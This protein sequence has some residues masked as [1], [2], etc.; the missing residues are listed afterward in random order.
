[1]AGKGFPVHLRDKSLYLVGIKGTGMSA[2][3]EILQAR[4]ARVCGS[5]TEETFYTDRVLADLGI[6]YHEGFSADHIHSGIDCIV[7]SAAYARDAHPELKKGDSLGIPIYTYPQA[8]GELSRRTS[9]SGISGTH[10]KTTTTA[11]VGTLVRFLRLPATVL[12]GSE[13][14]TFG[15]R[16]TLIQGE[17]YLVAESCEWQRSFLHYHP[18]RLIITNIE[19]E[20]LDYFRGLDDIVDAFEAFCRLLPAGG[21]LVYNQDCPGVQTL[22]PRLADRM[23][24]R[25]I[26]FGKTADGPYRITRISIGDGEFL[27]ELAGFPSAYRIRVP[28]EHSVYNAAAALAM[29]RDMAEEEAL[30]GEEA[31]TGEEAPGTDV[32]ERLLDGL[33]AFRGTRRRSE[34]IGQASGVTFMDD[35]A[36]HPTEIRKTLK[37][38]REFHPRRRIIADFMPHTYTRTRKLLGAFGGCFEPD[39]RVYLHKIYASARELDPGDISGKDLYREVARRH[40]DVHYYDE[41]E[42]AAS[43]LADELREGDLFITMGAG[44][45]W[46]L[47]RLLLERLSGHSGGER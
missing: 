4:G 36:H 47:G 39:D 3:A 24:I 28:A 41:P 6:P 23:D 1:M 43:D 9:F 19:E 26:P 15:N 2:L 16:S 38:I 33:R 34:T 46:R 18:R 21:T 12:A 22:L 11:M 27:F 31:L 10:G 37:G 8:L 20:H 14:P 45:N 35:Y 5:D 29:V 44:D 7:H 25:R 40:P 42:D 13:V 32:E 30:A 17:K